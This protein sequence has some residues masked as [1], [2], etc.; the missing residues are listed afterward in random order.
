M[1]ELTVKMPNGKS[2]SIEYEGPETPSVDSAKLEILRRQGVKVMRP[3]TQGPEDYRQHVTGGI[4]DF[5]TKAITP[6]KSLDKIS[7]DIP[8]DY[9]KGTTQRSLAEM[10]IPQSATGQLAALSTLGVAPIASRLAGA[11]VT[12]LQ[13]LV[14][15]SVR[16]GAGALGGGTG[17]VMSGEGDFGEG[18]LAGGAANLAGEAA[19][20]GGAAVLRRIPGVSGSIKS[21]DASKLGQLMEGALPGAGFKG[22]QGYQ[23]ALREGGTEKAAQAASQRVKDLFDAASGSYR[24]TKSNAPILFNNVSRELNIRAMP[25]MKVSE[26][27]HALSNIKDPVARERAMAELMTAFSDLDLAHKVPNGTFADL[28]NKHQDMY[29]KV[30]AL[31]DLGQAGAQVTGRQ[32]K[33]NMGKAAQELGDKSVDFQGRLK[34]VYG[35]TGNVLRRGAP[36]QY[37]DQV[38]APSAAGPGVSGNLKTGTFHPYVAGKIKSMTTPMYTGVPPLDPGNRMRSIA[39]IFAQGASDSG[40]PQDATADMDQWRRENSPAW[41]GGNGPR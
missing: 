39:D 6:R 4:T 41:L 14:G 26:A 23:Q 34:D 2:Y 9:G 27:M 5:L 19:M 13:R 7:A 21:A 33:F 24:L 37:G 32:T 35:E 25:P 36:P 18:A 12:P 40:T 10:A 15:P 22:T 11:A 3:P 38:Y 16:T 28:F 31:T 8:V 20:T 29:S 1:A 17:S 30:S